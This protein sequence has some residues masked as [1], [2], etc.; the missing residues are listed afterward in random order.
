MKKMHAIQRPVSPNCK[1]MVAFAV[2]KGKTVEWA[3]NTKRPHRTLK[4]LTPCQMEE[5]FNKNA[6]WDI[7]VRIAWLFHFLPRF[8]EVWIWAVSY[9]LWRDIFKKRCHTKDFEI[10]NDPTQSSSLIDL[11]ELGRVI[12]YGP[13]WETRTP[14]ILLPKQARYQLR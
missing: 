11:F 7:C 14:D 5:N 10:Q 13:R 2:W 12:H 4:N 3:Y 8:E 9:S 1:P 6:K